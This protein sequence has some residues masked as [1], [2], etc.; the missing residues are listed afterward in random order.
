M[1]QSKNTFYSQIK[2]YA[3]NYFTLIPI[4]ILLAAAS[5]LFNIIP[6]LYIWLIAKELLLNWED[7]VQTGSPNQLMLEEG[8]FR[9]MNNL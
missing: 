3:G 7:L 6:Y 8:Y 4:A 9:R 1:A 5:A 2:R